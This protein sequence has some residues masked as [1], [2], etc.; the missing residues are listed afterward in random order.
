MESLIPLPRGREIQGLTPSPMANTL[1]ERV[2]KTTPL[3][4]LRCTIS[5]DPGC[6]SRLRMT[7]TRPALAPRVIRDRAPQG[8]EGRRLRHPF[9]QRVR[10]R[11]GHQALHPGGQG[12]A[13]VQERQ[14][15]EGI[16]FESPL[17][18]VLTVLLG[19][20]ENRKKILKKK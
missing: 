2:A 20:S 3:L 13:R 6:F 16:S 15:Q 7:P 1:S 4:S 17:Q 10:H 18:K 8:Q 14:G 12:E 11:R 19:K 5:N 9:R